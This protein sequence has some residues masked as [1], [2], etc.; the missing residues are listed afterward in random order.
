MG[1]LRY[2]HK[3]NAGSSDYPADAAA[4]MVAASAGHIW[5]FYQQL[6]MLFCGCVHDDALHDNSYC[7]SIVK[8]F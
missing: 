7:Q 3:G 2:Q 8:P 4:I 1:S 5:Y 6:G